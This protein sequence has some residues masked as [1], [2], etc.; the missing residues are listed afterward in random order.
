MRPHARGGAS[1]QQLVGGAWPAETAATHRVATALSIGWAL[2]RPDTAAGSPRDRRGGEGGPTLSGVARARFLLRPRW[3]L[4]HL[5]VV[6]LIVLMVSLGFWQLRRLDDKK[7]RNALVEARMDQPVVA[8]DELVPVTAGDGA[9]DAARFRQVEATGTY[10]ARATVVVRNRS[11]DGRAGG[12]VVTPLTLAGGEQ[13]GI[14]RG[15]ARLDDEGRTPQPAPPEGR[16]TV[17]GLA[18]D[19]DRL[20]GTAGKDLD[21]LLETDGV[22]PVVVQAEASDPPDAAPDPAAAEGDAAAQAADQAAA[23]SA[24]AEAAGLVALP[25]PEL[26]E[27]PHLGYAMQWFIFSTIAL[28]GYPI[29]LRRVVARRGKEAGDDAGD[30]T[31]DHSDLDHEF[32]ALVREGR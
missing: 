31:G 16:V 24:E 13:V 32:E 30:D 5:L 28:V 22:L 3:L 6:L 18:M 12:W 7:D 21:G 9:V 10:D 2:A 26:S 8:V 27:G 11:Q 14:I 20:G 17:T 19:P 4:S 23:T 15:F 29:I 1:R 25:A